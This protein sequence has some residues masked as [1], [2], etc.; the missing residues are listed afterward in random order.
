MNTKFKKIL[1]WFLLIAGLVIIFWPLYFSYNIFMSKAS[2]PEIFKE[3]E[4]VEEEISEKGEAGPISQEELQEEMRKAVEEQI[5][6]MIP[7]EFLTKLLNLMS[8]SIFA[9]I[10]IFGGS[11]ISG[12]GLRLI[13]RD[14]G[15][16][17]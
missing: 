8:W 11:K 14:M 13:K 2:A 16:N 5:K 15:N 4:K 17:N 10:L 9:G 3:E 7:A 1:G 12:I 6:E